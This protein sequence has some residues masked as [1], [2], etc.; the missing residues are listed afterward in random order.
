MILIVDDKAENRYLLQS[1]FRG[2][3]HSVQI[4]KN[5]AQAL[6]LARQSPPDLVVA[7]VL[8]PVMDGFTLCRRWKTD[9]QLSAIPFVILT[10]TYSDVQ[11]EQFAL[12][13]GA[14][15]FLTKPAEPRK[16]MEV[17]RPLL[18]QPAPRGTAADSSAQPE[19]VYLKEYNEILVRKL[20]AKVEELEKRNLELAK[21]EE[22]KSR[23]LIVAAHELYT[24]LACVF[25]YSELLKQE[26]DSE[27]IAPL[28][29]GVER[30]LEV[31]RS[32]IQMS[33]AES[34]SLP[35][36]KVRFDL[37]DLVRERAAGLRAF[38]AHRNQTLQLD[39]PGGRLEVT[40]DPDEL[41]QAFLNLVLNAI[42]FTPDGGR[43]AIAASAVENACAVDVSDTGIGIPAEEHE[44]IFE[45]FHQLQNVIEH[46]SGTTEFL[47]GGLGLGLP[48]ARAIARKHG[49]DIEVRSR[50]GA[51]ST[52]TLRLPQAAPAA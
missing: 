26:S 35:A 18:G 41:A 39:L 47:S 13:Q 10:A 31:S 27:M 29:R 33:Q 9:P 44:R 37:N 23:F 25:G 24:P 17:V 50:V 8:M 11:D 21:K 51:G 34:D 38:S 19:P 43:I 2:H 20:V 30:L 46:H 1:L 16:I 7:D 36:K 4:A 22:M 42:R 28:C 12:K 48:I 6:E 14:D 49:G 15:A 5:G 32:I 52:F 3:G 45:K 40:G